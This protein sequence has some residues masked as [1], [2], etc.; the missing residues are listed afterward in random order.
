M[1]PKEGEH[2]T[3]FSF[4]DITEKLAIVI[5]T[6]TFGFVE[7][8]SGSMNNSALVLS[9]FFFMAIAVLMRVRMNVVKDEN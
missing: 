6:F 5:G 7:E 2:T 1:L 9:I 3:Y 8:I 4:Y